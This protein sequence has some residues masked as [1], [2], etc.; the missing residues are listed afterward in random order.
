MSRANGTVSGLVVSEF[1]SG[2]PVLLLHCTGSTGGQWAVLAKRLAPRFRAVTPDIA[3]WGTSSDR[4]G[5]PQTLEVEAALLAD[6][7]ASFDT[8]YHIVGHSMGGAVAL[9]L[10]LMQRARVKSLTLIE[11]VLFH[12]LRDGDET[13]RA[14]FVEPATLAAHMREG[15]RQGAAGSEAAM[16]E[17]VD[18]WNRPGAFDALD[19]AWRDSV[20]LRADTVAANFDALER[21]TF[22]LH[23]VRAVS[24]PT[25]MMVG[26]ATQPCTQRIAA[27]LFD[28]LPLAALATIHGAGHMLPFTHAEPV[29]D[30]IVAHIRAAD[31][32]G[33][34]ILPATAPTDRKAKHLP[35]AA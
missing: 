28:V 3:G 29:N 27:K 33:T 14:L 7:M 18:F 9:R 16:R 23:A 15:A 20:K 30:R 26:S 2:T 35:R 19:P 21:A 32:E 4:A 17:F 1:G 34:A 11:P 12:L 24:A 13:D 22:P 31:G 5:T 6:R 10:A 8:P 25:L